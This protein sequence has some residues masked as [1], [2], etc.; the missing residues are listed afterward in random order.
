MLNVRNYTDGQQVA[1]NKIVLNGS[2]ADATGVTRLQVNEQAIKMRGACNHE[3]FAGVGGALAPRVDLLRVQ[4]MRGVGMNAWRTSHNP[5][6]PVLLDITDRL[7][8]LVLDENRVLATRDNCDGCPNVPEYAGDPAADMGA[9]ALRDR[10][11]ASVAW[12]SL[13]NEAGCGNGSLLAGDLVEHAKEAAVARFRSGAWY[14]R[15]LARWESHDVELRKSLEAQKARYALVREIL[16]DDGGHTRDHGCRRFGCVWICRF[17]F[18]GCDPRGCVCVWP[19][20]SVG[21]CRWCFC[22]AVDQFL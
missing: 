1:H 4:Q 19:E 14:Q 18:E 15:W 21:L 12:Y 16:G 11:H 7:G 2:L 22:R 6:E 9:L 10:N 20:R 5:P 17:L 3:S 8:V 13:C